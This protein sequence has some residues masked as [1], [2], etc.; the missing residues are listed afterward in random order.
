[1]LRWIVQFPLFSAALLCCAS[2]PLESAEDCSE[3]EILCENRCIPEDEPCPS[4][5]GAKAP[6]DSSTDEGATAGCIDVATSNGTLNQQYQ[7][8]PIK[9]SGQQKSYYLITN[10]WNLYDGQSI[11]FDG[12]S[13]EVID[14]KDVSVPPTEGAPAGY[15]AF[16]IGRYGGNTTTRSNLPKAVS[17]I[18]SI[19]TAFSTN[20]VTHGTDN[21]NASYDV[22]FT[23]SA[24]G[25]PPGTYSPGAGGAY[26]MVWLYKPKDRQPRGGIGNTAN[27]PNREIEGVEGGWD[28]WLHPSTGDPPCVS[29]VSATPREK[30]SF[31]LADFIRDAVANEYFVTAEMYLSII[32]AGFE[33][34]GNGD[35]LRID[36]FCVDVR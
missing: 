18:T 23:Q 11:R 27:H 26:L 2:P 12:L 1:V 6:V 31:D 15:P 14:N 36:N 17:E 16:F 8:A 21:T 5:G 32:F 22:W 30:L 3:N 28:V 25:V 35:G 34:W 4:S 10:W 13:F 7:A 24:D 9:V 33:I 29:Y 20:A 19:P